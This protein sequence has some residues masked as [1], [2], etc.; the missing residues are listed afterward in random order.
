MSRRIKKVIMEELAVLYCDLSP[1]NLTCDGELS[2]S[3]V[4]AKE[5]HLYAKRGELFLELGERPEEEEV[6][7]YLDQFADKEVKELGLP[8]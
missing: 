3:E 8:Y 5:K 4:Q 1:E 6:Y 7:A 2:R